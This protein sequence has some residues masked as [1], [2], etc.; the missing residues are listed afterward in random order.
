MRLDGEFSYLYSIANVFTTNRKYLH[1]PIVSVHCPSENDRYSLL[2]PIATDTVHN[3]I[4]VDITEPNNLNAGFDKVTH[5]TAFSE[6][7]WL[8][9]RIIY[10]ISD[11]TLVDQRVLLLVFRKS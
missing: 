3:V 9:K 5:Q 8:F 11:I 4:W 10:D 7:S 6:K 2:P 1:A